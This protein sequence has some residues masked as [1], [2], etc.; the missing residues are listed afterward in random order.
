M[1]VS[2]ARPPLLP[3]L[4]LLECA[5]EPQITRAEILTRHTGTFRTGN[6]QLGRGTAPSKTLSGILFFSFRRCSCSVASLSNNAA[7]IA[8][9]KSSRAPTPS[10]GDYRCVVPPAVTTTSNVVP[11][12]QLILFQRLE[13]ALPATFLSFPSAAT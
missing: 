10:A 2:R 7:Q 1:V 13:R 6:R 3:P 9:V 4:L 11:A 8:S 12:S 5:L